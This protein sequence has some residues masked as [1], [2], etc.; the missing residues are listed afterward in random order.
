[1]CVAVCQCR[2]VAVPQ[3]PSHLLRTP[4]CTPLALILQTRQPSLR[5]PC[6]LIYFDSFQVL[7]P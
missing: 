1:M 5:L 3:S 2:R 4:K 6:P 7:D